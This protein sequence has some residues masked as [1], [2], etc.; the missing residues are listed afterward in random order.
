MRVRATFR[1]ATS[2]RPVRDLVARIRGAFGSSPAVRNE[3]RDN[4][5]HVHPSARLRDVRVHFDGNENTLSIGEHSRLNHT[6]IRFLGN[7]QTVSLGRRTKIQ[8]SAELALLDHGSAISIGSSTTIESAR[9]VSL[10][11][12]TIDVG[13]DCMLAYGIEIRSGDSHSIIDT[14]SNQRINLATPVFVADHVWICANATV[15]KGSRIERDSIVGLGAIVTGS[16][17]PSVILGG[18]PARVLRRGVTWDRK[19][20]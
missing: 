3:G 10:S 11:G 12:A 15:L 2:G 8:R 1:K 13:E 6:T 14:A 19:R 18:T 7:N 9:F 20:L 16:F 4:H 17:E 5:I